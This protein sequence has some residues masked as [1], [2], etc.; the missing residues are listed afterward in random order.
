M[1][2]VTVQSSNIH[3]VAHSPAEAKL[4]VIFKGKDGAPGSEYHY[5]GISS[6]QHAALMGAESI[7]AHLN[8][9]IKPHSSKIERHG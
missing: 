5:H 8:A 3:S 6:A 1:R 4:S 7:G 2:H 9:H